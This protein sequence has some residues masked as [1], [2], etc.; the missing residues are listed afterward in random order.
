MK[1]IIFSLIFFQII[2]LSYSNAQTYI[3]K[4][5]E[6]YVKGTGEKMGDEVHFTVIAVMA[7]KTVNIKF[8]TLAGDKVKYKPKE[9][10]G[11]MY[12]GFLFRSD[13]KSNIASLIDSANICFYI[14]GFA[15]LNQINTESDAAG[16]TEGYSYYLSNDINSPLCPLPVLCNGCREGAGVAPGGYYRKFK[17]EYPDHQS[18]YDCF[19]DSPMWEKIACITNYQKKEKKKKK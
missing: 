3:Y 11:F 19:D 14:N 8:V 18:L 2:L 13:N 9:F 10:W 15:R 1:K 17:D 6:D 4:T 7:V 16:S 12:K 5:Y